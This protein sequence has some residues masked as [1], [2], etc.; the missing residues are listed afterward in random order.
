MRKI[1]DTFKRKWS[2]YILEIIVIVLSIFGG[3]ELENW[4]ENRKEKQALKNYLEKIAT[5]IKEDI[6]VAQNM[7]ES[8]KDHSDLCA[9]AT[10]MIANRDFT[11][12]AQSTITNAVFVMIIEQPLNYNRSGFESLKSSGYL[13]HLDNPKVE[14]LI[15]EYYNASD[16]VIFEENSLQIWAN[17]LDLQLHKSGFFS[18]W[19]ELE[20]R[21]NQNIQEVLG[22]YTDQLCEHEGHDIVLSLLYRGYLFTAYLTGFYEEQIIAGKE[23]IKAINAFRNE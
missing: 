17:D 18:Q 6:I 11:S 5:N 7:L 21:P 10:E 14:E 12:E 16:K 9:D 22:N 13:Q 20:A 1:A 2:E 8:R 23:V 3:L 4:N 19:I 15:Y